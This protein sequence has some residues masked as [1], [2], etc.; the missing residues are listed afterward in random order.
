MAV[1]ASKSFLLSQK[2]RS[3]ELFIPEWD[4][5]VRLEAMNVE[6]RVAFITT[7]QEN[8][9]AIADHKKDPENHPSVE[10][11]DEAMLGIV[12][13]VVDENGDLM[14]TVNDIPDLKKLPYTQIQHIYLHLMS[15]AFAGG[16]IVKEVD[17]EKKG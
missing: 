17:D 16:D 1:L 9:K 8:V 3:T 15:M 5:T 4:A 6:R 14:F 13:S 12:F 2:P 11:L 10:P 7:M